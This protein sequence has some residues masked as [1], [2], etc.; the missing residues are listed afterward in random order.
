MTSL[1]LN[2]GIQSCFVITFEHFERLRV[3]LQEPCF[4]FLSPTTSWHGPGWAYMA[5][6][7]PRTW[8]RTGTRRTCRTPVLFDGLVWKPQDQS[9]T[10][11]MDTWLKNHQFLVENVLN[12]YVLKPF[13]WMW[14]WDC[15]PRILWWHWWLNFRRYHFD[16]FD[17]L[18]FPKEWDGW[19]LRNV[20]HLRIWYFANACHASSKKWWI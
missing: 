8:I 10:I 7:Q 20:L 16:I 15:H 2:G 14:I 13:M 4:F 11:S 5:L 18:L 12:T 3:T 1:W 17:V 6:A 19:G 9:G